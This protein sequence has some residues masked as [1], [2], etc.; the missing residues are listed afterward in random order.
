MGNYRIQINV[1][2]KRSLKYEKNISSIAAAIYLNLILF[3][4]FWLMWNWITPIF[5]ETSPHLTYLES[6]GCVLFIRLIK[7]IFSENIFNIK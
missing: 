4:F 2:F 1:N 3:A 6:G 5:W 7:I